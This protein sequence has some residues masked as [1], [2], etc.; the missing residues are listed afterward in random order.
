MDKL[1]LF[2]K[3]LYKIL[4]KLLAHIYLDNNII[5]IKGFGILLSYRKVD[6]NTIFIPRTDQF[7]YS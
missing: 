6:A 7:I 1:L 5:G 2:G 3:K 4:S